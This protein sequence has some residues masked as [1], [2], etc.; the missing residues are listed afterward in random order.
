MIGTA[1]APL[2]GSVGVTLGAVT[3]AVAAVVKVQMQLAAIALPA[4]SFAPVLIVAVKTVLGAKPPG[5][6]GMNVTILVTAS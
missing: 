5:A 4:R 6:V 2:A 3:S 1:M